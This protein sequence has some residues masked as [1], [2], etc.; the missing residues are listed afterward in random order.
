M[1]PRRH[2]IP[3][4]GAEELSQTLVQ[5]AG[6]VLERAKLQQARVELAMALQRHM[7]PAELPEVPG[8]QIAARYVPARAGLDVGGD[9]YD[10]I[11]MSGETVGIAIGD[12]EGHDVDAAAIVGQV[13]AGLHVV[14]GFTT[15][16]GD[17]LARINDLLVSMS[18][19][20]FLTCTFLR[21]DPASGE[22]A[23]ARA[24]HVPAVWATADGRCEVV[25]D[26]G[27]L[28]LGLFPRQKYPVTRRL[29]NKAGAFVLLTDGVVEGPAFPLE[30]G[31]ERVTRVVRSG[32]DADPDVLAARVISV[33]NLTGNSDDAAVLVVRHDGNPG[34]AS[35]AGGDGVAPFV[36]GGG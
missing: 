6:E 16:P 33:A 17:V 27:G 28:P 24:G 23:V 22:L 19:G 18:S 30:R 25:L 10:A 11:M 5:L 12:V 31:L 15:D 7:L 8:L 4:P 9:W 14:V 13:R 34:L 21:F 2:S 35:S 36:R 20:L 1:A 26:A 29:L 3:Y 32:F